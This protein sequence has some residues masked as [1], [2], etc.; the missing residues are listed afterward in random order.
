M[1]TI[2]SHG[3]IS[4]TKKALH[5]AVRTGIVQA[6]KRLR[7]VQEE[8]GHDAEGARS[9]EAAEDFMPFTTTGAS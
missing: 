2:P 8:T 3:K 4:K 9:T 6:E 1:K 5:T 7:K